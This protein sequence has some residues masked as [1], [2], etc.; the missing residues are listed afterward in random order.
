MEE[1]S[2]TSGVSLGGDCDT[3]EPLS[4]SVRQF[5]AARVSEITS[6]TAQIG[7]LVGISGPLIELRMK[8]RSLVK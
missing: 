4:L 5:I 7:K 3:G 6:L 8:Y 2:E 1:D